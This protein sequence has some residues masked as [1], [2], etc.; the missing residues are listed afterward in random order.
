MTLNQTLYT[1]EKM[2]IFKH[3]IKSV[4]F[5][6]KISVFSLFNIHCNLLYNNII[7]VNL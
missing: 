7:N 4:Q 5:S 6:L 2:L 1:D 3:A